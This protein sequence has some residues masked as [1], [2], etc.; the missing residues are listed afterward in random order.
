[1]SGRF[2]VIEGPNG[3]GKTTIAKFLTLQLQREGLPVHL[4]TEPSASPLG[5]LLRTA[6]EGLSGHAF[7]LAIAADRCDHT[8]N[9]ILPAVKAGKTVVSDRYVQSSLVL[10]RI[11]GIELHKLW[12]Y[13]DCAL[14]PD[15]SFYLTNT[16]GVLKE[17]LSARGQRSRL[18]EKGTPQR[19]LQFYDEARLFL[20]H[21]GWRQF[22]VDCHERS[23]D[24]IVGRI[25]Q[26]IDAVAE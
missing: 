10:Q 5:N 4:T 2:F 9:E 22:T 1:M 23:P 25:R 24:D 19:E 26:H 3:V 11:D 21:H 12:L 20:D 7:A 15:A 8:Q 14:K 17:R 6:E 18:E 13:N 16:D